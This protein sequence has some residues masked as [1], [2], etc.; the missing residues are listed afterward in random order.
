MGWGA[1]MQLNHSILV[2]EIDGQCVNYPGVQRWC[3]Y[4]KPSCLV[5]WKDS[6]DALPVKHP[7]DYS[8]CYFLIFF[9]VQTFSLSI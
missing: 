4:L 2:T 7:N 6:L 1:G 8:A 3:P 9:D 5:S